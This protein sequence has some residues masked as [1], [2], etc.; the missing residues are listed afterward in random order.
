MHVRQLL[1]LIL[2]RDAMAIYFQDYFALDVLCKCTI[3]TQNEILIRLCLFLCYEALA[4][5]Q[6]QEDGQWWLSLYNNV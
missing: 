2:Y 6:C 5:R 3:P 4:I 1:C